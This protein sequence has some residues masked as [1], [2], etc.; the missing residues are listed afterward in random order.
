MIAEVYNAFV[1]A[2]CPKDI[3]EKAAIALSSETKRE[4]EIIK[5]DIQRIELKVDKLLDSRA[6]YFKMDG[7]WN[8][9]SVPKINNPII[10]FIIHL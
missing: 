2:K 5:I 1:Q 7:R 8:R 3:A 10:F 4:S 6:G 9:G